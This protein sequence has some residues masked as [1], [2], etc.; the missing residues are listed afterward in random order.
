MHPQTQELRERYNPDGSQLRLL[1]LK[2]LEILVV[3]DDI[4]TRHNLSYWLSGGTLL[5]AVVHDGFIPWDDDIDIEM[6]RDDYKKLLKILEKEL[7]EHL[8]LQTTKEKGYSLLMSKVRDKNSIVYMKDEDMSRYPYKGFFIDIVPIERSYPWMKKMLDFTYGR[9]FRRL[10]RKR[11][12]TLKNI[13][14]YAVSLVLYPLSRSAISICR[15]ICRLTKPESLVYTYGITAKH[16]QP[17]ENI[18]PTSKICFEGQEFSAPH[19]PHEYLFTQYRCDY[20]IIP[21]ENGRPQHFEKVEFIN[22]QD[23]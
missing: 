14:E 19:K 8:Y 20:T 15:F 5:G 2:M 17:Y 6:M 1:Q 12:D 7:P 11:L 10:K 22:N 16:T 9:A 21:G 3:V 23:T 18:F 4:C 13:Y